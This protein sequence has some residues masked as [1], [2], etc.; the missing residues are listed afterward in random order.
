MAKQPGKPVPSERTS[1]VRQSLGQALS[2][3]PQSARELSAL[4]GIP[5]K[6]VAEHLDHLARSLPRSGQRLVVA[7]ARC[8]GCGFRFESSK[9][10]RPS[11]CPKCRRERIEAPRFSVE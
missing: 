11:R 7:P 3:F 9:I 4:V 8:K 6:E 1:T 5:E 2:S 10:R